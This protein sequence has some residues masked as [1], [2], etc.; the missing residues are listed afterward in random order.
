MI[1]VCLLFVWFSHDRTLSIS[2]AEE[3][4]LEFTLTLNHELNNVNNWLTSNRICINA[5]KTKYMIPCRKLFHLTNINIRF[6]TIE[7]TN[8]IK[9]LGII[10]DKHF[11]FK[12]HVDVIARKISKSVGILFILSKYLPLEVTKRLYYSLINP[13][14]LYGIEV[15]HGTY[16]DITNKIFILQKRPAGPSIIWFQYSHNR[17]TFKIQTK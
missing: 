17:N 10:F 2:F 6:V 16:A 9:F 12:K 5:D 1:I 8:N 14:L 15:W 11:T 4:A 7:E 3:S 13:F